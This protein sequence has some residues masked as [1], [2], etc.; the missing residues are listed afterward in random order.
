[1]EGGRGGGG[2]EGTAFLLDVNGAPLELFQE[3]RLA[4][5]GNWPGLNWRFRP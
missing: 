2:V 5:A 3:A 1:M 4:E